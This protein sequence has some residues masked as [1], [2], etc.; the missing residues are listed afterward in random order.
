MGNIIS[1]DANFQ[2]AERIA[3]K[4]I[5]S[6]KGKIKTRQKGLLSTETSI[7]ASRDIDNLMVWFLVYC[8]YF[9]EV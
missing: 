8:T 1:S 5:I 2:A 9:M 7:N 6:F 4:H 3:L